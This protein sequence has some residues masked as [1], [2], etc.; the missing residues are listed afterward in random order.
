MSSALEIGKNVQ[1]QITVASEYPQRIDFK[2]RLAV[3]RITLEIFCQLRV[4]VGPDVCR[5]RKI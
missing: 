5:D 4:V 1:I 3:Q 2:N